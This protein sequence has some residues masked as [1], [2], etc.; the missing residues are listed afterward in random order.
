MPL[1]EAIQVLTN[2]RIHADDTVPVP[3]TSKTCSGRV[4]T[5]GILPAMLD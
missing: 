1:V 5:D 3:A 2:V 4:W